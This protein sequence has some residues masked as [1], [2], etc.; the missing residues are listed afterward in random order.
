VNLDCLLINAPSRVGVYGPLTEFAAI[1][2]PVWAGLIATYLRNRGYEVRILDAEALGLDA[3]QTATTIIDYDPRLAVFCIHGQQPSASTQCMPG[4]IAVVEALKGSGI[5]TAALGGHPSALPDQTLKDG[6]DRVAIGEG[7]TNIEEM[8]CGGL[9]RLGGNATNLDESYPRQALDLLDMTRYRAHN[10]HLWTGKRDGGYAS[11]QTSLGCS[12]ACSFCMIN[13][14]F[15]GPGM[16]YWSPENVLKQLDEIVALGITNIKIPDEMFCLNKRHVTA[17]CDG[18]IERKYGVDLNFWCYARIDTMRDDAMLAKMKL[19]GI[20]WVAVGIE[21]GSKHVRDGVEKGRFGN[22]QIA[23]TVERVRTHDLS[24][25][26]NYI[27]GLPDDDLGSMG[28]TLSLARSL[29]TPW[30]NFYCAQ[31]YPGSALHRASSGKGV[32]P[33]DA[34]GP[35]WIGYSQHAYDSWPLPTDTLTREQVL[36]FRDEAFLTY[37]RDPGYLAM[38]AREFGQPTVDEIERM[39]AVGKPKRRHRDG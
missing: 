18:I 34:R 24:V 33:E 35:G 28:E 12:F 13:N 4:A 3:T 39:T 19:A 36:D 9:G 10:W 2:P 31:A 27:F 17:I 6:F 15:G 7:A 20:N 30:A 26:A 37:F 11:L 21:S 16:R 5:R 25:G 32:L 14:Q 1:E 38:M 8:L 23:E 29:N 22:E